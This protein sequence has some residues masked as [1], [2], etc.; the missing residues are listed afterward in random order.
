[1]REGDWN[2]EIEKREGGKGGRGDYKGGKRGVGERHR[3]GGKQGEG[4]RERNG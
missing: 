2:E 1:M 3:Y 4:R